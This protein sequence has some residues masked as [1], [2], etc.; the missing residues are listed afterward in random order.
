MYSVANGW[1]YNMEG[2]EGGWLIAGGNHVDAYRL[3]FQYG[4]SDAVMVGSKVICDEGCDPIPPADLSAC[5][6]GFLWQPYG[7]LSWSHIQSADSNLIAK[8]DAQRQEWQR[9]EL[10]SNRK[11][12]AQIVVTWSGDKHN[13]SRDFLEGRIFKEVHPNGDP[14]EVYIVTSV[15]GANKIRSRAYLYGLEAR[16]EDILI[17]LSPQ[18]LPDEIDLKIL[19]ELLYHKYDMRVINH[20]GGQGVLRKFA[21]AKILPQLNLSLMRKRSLKDIITTSEM[22]S[23]EQRSYGLSN[24]PNK[25]QNFFHSTSD[26]SIPSALKPVSVISDSGDN[27]AIVTFSAISVDDL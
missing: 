24:F 21:Q 6:R 15:N 14:F 5:K 7:P 4:V 18:D 10:L 27:I 26:G 8:V 20:D 2:L 23:P 11:Y 17:V 12:P 3:G 19:P 9:L 22:L 25:V 1:S 13:S 16:I